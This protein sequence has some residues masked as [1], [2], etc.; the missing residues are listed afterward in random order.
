MLLVSVLLI[1]A[2]ILLLVLTMLRTQHLISILYEQGPWR[3]LRNLLGFFALG[4]AVYLLSVLMAWPVNRELIVAEVFFL[5]ALFM[6]LAVRFSFRT[7]HDVTRLDEAEQLVNRDETTG[8]FN[9][10][11]IL[12]LL[13]Q[14]FW[15]AQ[16]FG[17]PLGLAMVDLE[18]L[19]G[20][21]EEHGREAAR[22]VHR[23][24]GE[25]LDGELRDVDLVGRVEP[26][27][28]LCLLPS[29]TL[30]G[31]SITAERLLGRLRTLRFIE[32]E[33]RMVRDPRPDQLRDGLHLPVRI[34][35]STM[36]DA[37]RTPGQALEAAARAVELAR[38]K[39]V[40]RMES[41]ETP[42][43]AVDRG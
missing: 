35:V 2:G 20:I 13:N 12:Y 30:A 17:F 29:T 39:G 1:G 9:R 38:K 8:L 5:A 33:G 27:R 32:Q 10:D 14:E 19:E 36:T 41:V 6:F 34:G 42:Q 7:I 43:G 11:A 24:V 23:E 3:S 40:N 15:K 37:V 4:Y 22:T 28:F 21:E 18:G 25:L 26:D 16:R 31:S